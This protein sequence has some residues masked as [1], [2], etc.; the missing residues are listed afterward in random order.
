M[1]W[2]KNGLKS[3]LKTL[4]NKPQLIFITLVFVGLFGIAINFFHLNKNVIAYT[5]FG[6]AIIIFIITYKPKKKEIR[7]EKQDE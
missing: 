3:E 7:E 2:I 5:L 4:K 6:L 1:N